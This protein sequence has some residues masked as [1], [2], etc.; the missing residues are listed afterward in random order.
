MINPLQLCGVLV[1]LLVVIVIGIRSGHHVKNTTDFESGGG[2]TNSGFVSGIMM[3]S[4]IGGSS[5]IG[6][7]QAAYTQGISACWYALSCGLSCLVIALLYIKP[8]RHAKA[9]TLLGLIGREYGAHTELA[10]AILV[11][12]SAFVTVI[13]QLISSS[14]VLPVIFPGLSV[15]SSVVLTAGLVLVYLVFGGA[16][17]A[18]QLGK[19]K[20]LLL[21]IAVLSGT[22]IV[23]KETGL[24]FLFNTLDHSY[25]DLF[26]NGVSEEGST[27]L[28]VIL[29]MITSQLYMQAVTSATSN[30]TAKHGELISALLIPPVGIASALIGMFMRVVHPELANPKDAFSQFVLLYMPDFLGGIVLAALLLAIVGSSAGSLLDLVT[31]IR[32]DIVGPRIHRFAD[33]RYS[34][35][36]TRLCIIVLL[37]TA[38]FLSSGILGDAV[39]FFT[40][41]SVGLRAAAIFAPLM[42]A[43]LFPGKI[44]RYCAFAA[45]ITGALLSVFFGL[46]DILPINGACVGTLG[47]ALFCALG[48]IFKRKQALLNSDQ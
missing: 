10:S 29:G 42:C 47:S 16:L 34:L 2:N 7:A 33:L 26:V 21:Y 32:R 9:P 46:W 5:T 36:F 41:A 18:S 3:G 30:R 48:A 25:F 15:R 38:C 44:D 8:F 28:S 45:V 11:C 24:A 27:A 40:T 14:A 39:L 4:M 1:I 20:A 22:Y 35:T 43:M 13:P 31:V 6:I 23:M 12:F 17:G 19:V 37:A